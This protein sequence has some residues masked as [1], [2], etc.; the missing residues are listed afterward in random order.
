M[1]GLEGQVA[2]DTNHDPLSPGIGA[3]DPK[4][5]PSTEANITPFSRATDASKRS[6]QVHKFVWPLFA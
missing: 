2:L 5:Q 4:G 3:Q 1:T 6:K